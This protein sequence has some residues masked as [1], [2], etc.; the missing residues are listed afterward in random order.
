VKYQELLEGSPSERSEEIRQRVIRARQ[1]Q[2]ERFRDEGIYCNTQMGPKQIKRYCKLSPGAKDLLQG[3]MRQLG[4]SAR[5]FDRI[6]KVSRTIADL[7]GKEEIAEE[8]VLEALNYRTL[9]R[10]SLY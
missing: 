6:L 1:M 10:Q 3:A 7:Q 4:I 2:L 9:D 5:A 8:H